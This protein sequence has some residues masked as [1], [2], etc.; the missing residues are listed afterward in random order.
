MTSKQWALENKDG[1]DFDDLHDDLDDLGDDLPSHGGG[2][3]SPWTARK[4]RPP[5][6]DPDDDEPRPSPSSAD[7]LVQPPPAGLTRRERRDHREREAQRIA[8]LWAAYPA[9]RLRLPRRL[10]RRGR[11]AFRDVHRQNMATRRAQQLD[12]AHRERAAGALVVA[13][14][15]AVVLLVRVVVF[16]GGES[17]SATPVTSEPAPSTTAPAP[18]S[19]ADVTPVPVS[20]PDAAVVAVQTWFDTVC[21]SSPDH[22]TQARWDAVRSLMTEQAWAAA[23]A[24]MTDSSPISTWSCAPTAASRAAEPPVDGVAIVNYSTTRTITPLSGSAPAVVEHIAGARVVLQGSDGAWLIDR[25]P[26]SEH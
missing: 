3:Y 20:T 1:D 7:F 25:I 23:T 15:I 14:I 5:L 6:S 24:A 21:P 11:Q 4:S 12:A 18:T 26:E 10:G 19:Q 17:E 8:Q 2:V 22:T 9:R 13:V 16:S